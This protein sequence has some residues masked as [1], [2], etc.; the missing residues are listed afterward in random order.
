[1][2][3]GGDHVHGYRDAWI[4][5]VPEISEDFIR[6]EVGG[7]DPLRD[8]GFRAVLICDL[9]CEF[10]KARTIRDLLAE[11]VAFGEYFARDADDIVRVRIVFGKDERLRRFGASRKSFG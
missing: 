10:R 5:A 11:L 3:A 6:R 7:L 9:L 4:E 2:R 8:V 1:V